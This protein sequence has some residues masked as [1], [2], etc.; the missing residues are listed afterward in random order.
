MIPE[1]P[2]TQEQLP[3]SRHVAPFKQ[4]NSAPE[5]HPITRKIRYLKNLKIIYQET[6]TVK[7]SVSFLNRNG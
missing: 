3:F 4:L 5:L 1:Y 7:S 6:H 2:R